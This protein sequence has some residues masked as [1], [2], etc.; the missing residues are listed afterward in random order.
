MLKK[1]FRQIFRN[2][3]MLPMIFILPVVQ[4]LVLSFA[5]TFDIKSIRIHIVNQ[6]HTSVS[7][8]LIQKYQSSPFYKISGY[9]E[10]YKEAEYQIRTNKTDVVL[11][12]PK[13]FE[14]DLI[15][16]NAA[17]LQFVVNAINSSAAGIIQAYSFS[18]AMDFNK[19]FVEQKS[20]VTIT[21]PFNINYSYWYNPELNYKTYM[22]PG[23]LVL[24]VTIISMF[25]SAMNVV[26]EKEIGT[27]EQINVTPISK[28]QFLLG[29]LLP[30]CFIALFELALGLT[31]ARFVFNIHILG[32]I[33][34][35]FGVTLVYVVAVIGLGLFISTLTN[36]QQQAMFIAW[37]FMV[38]FIM[39]SGLFTP[40][41]SMPN[42]AKN[43]NVINPIAYFIKIIRMVIL[44]GS[45]F[46][47]ISK[48]FYALLIY[49]FCSMSFAVVRYRKKN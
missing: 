35:I 9:S 12:I 1:E 44:K 29:K 28:F 13:N 37:F 20:G 31:V 17:P 7:R 41:D 43:L 15:K 22:V 8:A 33:P 36:T 18:I 34:L 25:L 45:G 2:R 23:I 4:L 49:A 42:W 10:S 27:I 38:V 11:I 48:E 19:N 46:S 21:E 32:S 5:A 3:S 26:K 30:F 6:D 40:I 24:L 39:M 16:E 47:E 14:K